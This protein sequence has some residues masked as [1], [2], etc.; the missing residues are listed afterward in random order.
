VLVDWEREAVDWPGL[1]V[2]RRLC[3]GDGDALLGSFE[4][5]AG[6]C[7]RPSLTLPRDSHDAARRAREWPRP[8]SHRRRSRV[9][10]NPGYADRALDEA[11]SRRTT[12]QR[13]AQKTEDR[14]VWYRH[15]PLYGREVFVECEVARGRGTA[16]L[17]CKAPSDDRRERLEIPAWMFDRGACARMQL[18]SEPRVSW[19]A[20]ANLKQLLRDASRAEAESLERRH[21]PTE[22]DVDDQAKTCVQD[23]ATGTLSSRHQDARMAKTAGGGPEGRDKAN[24]KTASRASRT[25]SAPRRHR[26]RGGKR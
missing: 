14:R 24:R 13:N 12:T 22:E 26:G 21:Q 5:C 18:G 16:S 3:D 4:G 1:A 6:S 10:L 8:C 17:R 19:E 9:L 15:H 2:R 25:G 7:R 11:A 23:S 20:L